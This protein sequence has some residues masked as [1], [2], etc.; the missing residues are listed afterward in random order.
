MKPQAEAYDVCLSFAGEDR[1]YVE[2]VAQ[3]LRAAGVRV[4][5]DAYEEAELWGK[6]L[7]QHL[8]DVYQNRGKYCIVFLSKEYA[9][10]VW[11]RHELKNAQARAFKENREYLLPARFDDTELPGVPSTV[12]Y[13]DLRT[14]TPQQFADLV[15]RKLQSPEQTGSASESVVHDAPSTSS[16]PNGATPASISQAALEY[17]WDL[18]RAARLAVVITAGVVLTLFALWA[19]LPKTNKQSVIEW[20]LPGQTTDTNDLQKTADTAPG[21]GMTAGEQSGGQTSVPLADSADEPPTGPFP[22][23]LHNFEWGQ[24][25]PVSLKAA[26]LLGHAN[27]PE[28]GNVN[29]RLGVSEEQYIAEFAPMLRDELAIRGVTTLIESDAPEKLRSLEGKAHEYPVV[30]GLHVNAAPT[31]KASASGS[32]TYVSP[33]APPAV[34]DLATRL[35]Q[36]TVTHLALRDR[37]VRAPP[38][39]P[40]QISIV[41]RSILMEL[42]FITNDADYKQAFSKRRQLAA[43]LA[44]VIA[45]YLRELET[46]QS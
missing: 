38:S 18:P 30:I 19:S 42:F 43:A 4:F 14:R 26:I 28:S 23:P 10:K 20:L 24:V 35:H 1:A 27:R 45:T 5:Y 22:N 36:A 44:D 37:G 6:D 9:S 39:A 15:L 17:I 29:R 13:I 16:S 21:P 32:E 2:D 12:A 7:Y 25:T 34:R 11:T 41:P 33:D 46:K 40:A 3:A 31:D 8:A